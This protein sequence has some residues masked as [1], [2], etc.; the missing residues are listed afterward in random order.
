MTK[1]QHLLPLVLTFAIVVGILTVVQLQIRYSAVGVTLVIVAYLI[2]NIGYSI[3]QG[4]FS[5]K[6]L[7]EIGLVA[8]ICQ[9]AA[10]S[11]LI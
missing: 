8:I 1:Q 5:L 10:L 3:K 6:R 9:Y 2:L 4:S 7:I 11:Y